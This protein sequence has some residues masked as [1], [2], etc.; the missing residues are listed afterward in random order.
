MFE[1][2]Q[3]I[4]AEIF[5]F[6]NTTI[7]NVITDFIMPLI[8]NDKGLRVIYALA[9]IILL[10]KGNKTLRWM[11]L[12]SIIVMVLSDQIS[13]GL[14]KNWIGR[15]RPCHTFDHEL[16]NLL[17]GCGGGKSMP[18]AHAANAFGQAIFFSYYYTQ[19]RV[20]LFTYA[21]LIALSRVFVGVHYLS[22]IVAGA[23]VGVISAFVIVFVFNAFKRKYIENDAIISNNTYT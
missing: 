21:S 2:L 18:S 14:L 12:G 9:M 13:A 1:T 10:V 4:D 11:V 15:P 7:A 3:Q 22:D 5:F 20:Y 8:T 19:A 16:I 17:V 23:I 6:I